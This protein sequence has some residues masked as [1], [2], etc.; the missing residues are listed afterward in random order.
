MPG[1]KSGERTAAGGRR[2]GVCAE[3]RRADRKASGEAAYGIYELPGFEAGREISGR[4]A[5]EYIMV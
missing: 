2:S 4:K 1:G 3:L 5:R